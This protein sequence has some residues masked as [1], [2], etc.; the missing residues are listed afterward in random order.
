MFSDGSGGQGAGGPAAPGWGSIWRTEWVLEANTARLEAKISL[1]DLG[2]S[3]PPL[4]WALIFHPQ[5]KPERSFLKALS[6]DTK[7]FI[8][9]QNLVL[10]CFSL[11]MTM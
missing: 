8:I 3:P 1:C 2:H 10:L 5:N 11:L 9:S 4:L 6:A 7:I